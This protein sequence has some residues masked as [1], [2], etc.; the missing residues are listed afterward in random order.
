VISVEGNFSLVYRTSAS[1]SVFESI[2]TLI[3]A[4]RLDVGKSP[5]GFINPVIYEYPELILPRGGEPGVWDAGFTV[6]T[7]W[8]PLTDLGTPNFPKMVA[9]WLLLA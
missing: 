9:K 8:D 6:V 4:A 1:S 5:V 2:V 3:N 7:G